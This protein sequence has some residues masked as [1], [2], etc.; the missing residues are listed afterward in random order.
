[1]VEEDEREFLPGK[2]RSRLDETKKVDFEMQSDEEE[3][4]MKH[5]A[6]VARK[7][8]DIR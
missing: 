2:G 3:G 5:G 6:N 1:M 7:E 4:V 8:E